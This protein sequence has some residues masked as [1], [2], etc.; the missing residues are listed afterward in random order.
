VVSPVDRRSAARAAA[1]ARFVPT[2]RRSVA[3]VGSPDSFDHAC[4]T[5]NR[6]H[7]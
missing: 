7:V 2:G 6:P 5:I 3:A 1:E 4:A